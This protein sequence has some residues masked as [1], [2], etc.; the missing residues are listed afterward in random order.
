M[1]ANI[2]EMFLN[3]LEVEAQC[4]AVVERQEVLSRSLGRNPA[5]AH[6]NDDL[7][8]DLSD[9][10]FDQFRE[11]C[12]Q[13]VKVVPGRLPGSIR[14]ALL[15]VEPQ[16]MTE[17]KELDLKVEACRIR[18][19]MVEHAILEASPVSMAEALAKLRFISGIMLDG[20]EM[21]PL[22][23]AHALEECTFL[24]A[25]HLPASLPTAIS[26]WQLG[27]TPNNS[28]DYVVH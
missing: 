26:K 28:P 4:E 23:F 17:L 3:Y 7:H 1:A 10:T 2:I 20:A 24:I 15:S 19:A 9:L 21:E 13:I 16:V 12:E 27:A 5:P 25:R 6:A 14:S 11:Y 18:M 22:Y 8:R